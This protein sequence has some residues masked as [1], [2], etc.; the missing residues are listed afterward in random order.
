MLKVC[1]NTGNPHR[2]LQLW[3]PMSNNAAHLNK[4]LLSGM[5]SI[6]AAVKTPEALIVGKSVCVHVSHFPT[7]KAILC[8]AA[9][10]MFT[11]CGSPESAIEFWKEMSLSPNE[12]DV[13][14]C[15][16]VLAACS[17]LAPSSVALS[18]GKAV[19]LLMDQSPHIQRNAQLESTLLTFYVKCGQ[20][21]VALSHWQRISK[22]INAD[23]ILYPC[24]IFFR[25]LLLI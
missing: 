15:T 17:S 5:L 10:N 22:D 24:A 20:Y 14:L 13:A 11:K 9:M 4:H 2:A 1:K 8:T 23:T 16:T 12:I 21:D 6:C 3:T 7:A 19:Q 18:V 25:L